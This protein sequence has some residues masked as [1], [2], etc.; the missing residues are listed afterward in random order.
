[1]EPG[2]PLG[3]YRIVDGV[4]VRAFWSVSVYNRGGFFEKKDLGRYPVSSVTARADG[5]GAVIINFGGDPSLPDQI[6]IVGGWNYVVRLYQ[7]EPQ[8]LNGSW[9]FRE[10]ETP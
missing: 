2:L 8:V 1:V 5:D 10:L 6:P 4:P 7:P 9:S 3:H